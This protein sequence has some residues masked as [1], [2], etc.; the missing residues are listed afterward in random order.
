MVK[1]E[2][3]NVAKDAFGGTDVR[4]TTHG[5]RHLG[6]AIGSKT[7][8]GEYVGNK[9]HEWTND[10]MNL[11]RIA[12]SQPHAA[13]AAYIHGLSNRWSY[14]LR[15]V[16][17]IGDLIQPLEDAIHMRLISALTGRPPCSSIER[18]L[19][20]LPLRDPSTMASACFQSSQRIT[21][22]LVALIICQDENETVDCNNVRTVKS[23]IKRKNRQRQDEHAEITYNQLTPKMKR[24]VELSRE[25]GSSS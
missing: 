18:D 17:E 12:S 19:L 22:S 15:T 21:A 1:P 11:A 5:K 3:E 24:C 8:T 6:A 2:F 9:V 25:K 10:I 23:E 16:R 20:S 14:L 7:F 13:Y 4:I